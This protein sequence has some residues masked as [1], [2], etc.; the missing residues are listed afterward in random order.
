MQELKSKDV[1]HN[2]KV[3]NKFFKEDFVNVRT[4]RVSL[5]FCSRSL[6]LMEEHRVA[7]SLSYRIPAE[8]DYGWLGRHM[9]VMTHVYVCHGYLACWFISGRVRIRLWV[10]MAPSDSHLLVSGPCRLPR[11]K[12][13]SCHSGSVSRVARLHHGFSSEKLFRIR[14]NPKNPTRETN[15]PGN[16]ARAA[17]LTLTL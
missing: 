17:R 13:L 9:C 3:Q 6:W 16:I 12:L 15:Q 4:F 14:R 2:P 7:L 11:A 10:R 5:R 1:V 8:L